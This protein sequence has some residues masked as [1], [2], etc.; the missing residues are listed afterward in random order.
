[1]P[2]IG[3]VS[4]LAVGAW[5][6]LIPPSSSGNEPARRPATEVVVDA[7]EVA[8]IC[9]PSVVDSAEITQV[10][11][12]TEL[13]GDKVSAAGRGSGDLT[14]FLVETCQTPSRTQAFV[15]GSTELGE[16]T[17]LVLTN[18]ADVPVKADVQ[19][20]DA[21]GAELEA[22][23]NLV[24]PALSTVGLL[25]GTYAQGLAS[26]MVVVSAEGVGVGA[27][28]QTSGLDGEVALGVGRMVGAAPSYTQVIPGIEGGTQSGLRIGNLGADP[29]TV[30]VQVMSRD[31]SV[32]LEGAASVKIAPRSTAQ[33]SLDGLQTGD[34]AIVVEA[35]REIVAAVT[36]TH[37]GAEHPQV[38][39]ANYASRTVIGPARQISEANLV[40]AAQLNKVAGQLGFEGVSVALA[41]ANT[42]GDAANLDIQGTQKTL[43]PGA[44]QTY[45]LLPEAS[46][47]RFTSDTPVHV[48]YVVTATTDVGEIRSVAALG[49]GG[50]L[51]QTRS[52]VL[53][54]GG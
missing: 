37:V 52:V 6:T 9:G 18:P 8:L 40:T 10:G 16:D 34:G 32:A 27:W 51:A 20:F 26:P 47:N 3:A 48:A 39:D 11:R 30:E 14:A 35:D 1:M 5:F 13:E 2:A 19:I 50:T 4:L 15:A 44:T 33:V 45:M 36:E 17:V 54:P 12:A 38:E 41:V 42:T 21:N 7:G 22:P 53:E 28:L 23:V 46:R 49:V 24:V 29:A 31:G 25:P 43:A